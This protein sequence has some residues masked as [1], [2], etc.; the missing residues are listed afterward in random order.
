MKLQ[1][2]TNFVWILGHDS[3]IFESVIHPVIHPVDTASHVWNKACEVGGKCSS[4]LGEVYESAVD[5]IS[6][7]ISD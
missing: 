5:T 1:L 6:S 3:G 4:K 2:E 7:T